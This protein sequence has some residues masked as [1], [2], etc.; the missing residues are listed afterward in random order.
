MI[1]RPESEQAPD[2]DLTKAT[3]PQPGHFLKDEDTDTDVKSSE[4]DDE[5]DGMGKPDYLG[6]TNLENRDEES[7]ENE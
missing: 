1:E 4:I 5:S 3:T 6:K 7:P 2:S